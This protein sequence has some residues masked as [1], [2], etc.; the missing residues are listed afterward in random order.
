MAGRG[1]SDITNR[2]D[3]RRS[4]RRVELNLCGTG[5][6]TAS[7]R[8]H[9]CSLQKTAVHGVLLL[10]CAVPTVRAFPTDGAQVRSKCDF[11]AKFGF[12]HDLADSRPRDRSTVTYSN[13]HY[14]PAAPRCSPDCGP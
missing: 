2:G 14:A 9:D 12:D 7:E 3:D 11:L 5:A 13:S 1:D 8:E 4:L 6:N 10:F